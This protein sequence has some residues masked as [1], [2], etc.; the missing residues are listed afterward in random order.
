MDSASTQAAVINGEAVDC[1]SSADRGLSYGDGVFETLA[2]EQGV[3]RFWQRH[4]TRLL[5]GCRRLL[6]SDVDTGRLFEEAG[7]LLAGEGR[8]VLKI[9]ITRGI[10][11]R[12]YGPAGCGQPTRILQRHV[13]PALPDAHY[14]EGVRV[15]LCD[16]RLS[17]NPRLAG[18]K[19]LNRLEQVLARSE[20]DDP[21]I[22]EGL[23]LDVDG[24]LV[25][26]TMSN[27]FLL[28]KGRLLTPVLSHCGVAGIMRSVVM[29]QARQL[30]LPVQAMAVS[31]DDLA[32]ADEVFLTNSL[33]GI[34]PV[35]RIDARD[36]S[37][38]PVTRQLQDALA[39]LTEEGTGWMSDDMPDGRND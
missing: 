9:V 24:R 4:M 31:P 14:R 23:V 20:W 25:E 39:G 10:G 1:I 30:G 7:A 36:Y 17:R 32:Q 34:W 15:R 6:I 22:Q 13:A 3:P 33:I 26:G 29:E 5:A 27:V 38:G 19:H 12:G 21:D 16:S 35:R 37:V 8:C 2:V 11:G 28:A 18:I